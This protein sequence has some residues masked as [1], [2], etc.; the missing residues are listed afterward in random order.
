[1]P[2]PQKVT[3]DTGER[4]D[5]FRVSITGDGLTG[6][7]ECDFGP[8]IEAGTPNVVND[9]EVRVR[10]AIDEKAPLIKRDVVVTNSSG[11]SGTLPR[12]FEVV[13]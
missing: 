4:G 2:I 5:R 1:M 3:P 9:G 13:A 6:V 7:V 8:G 11:V 10:I 12:G